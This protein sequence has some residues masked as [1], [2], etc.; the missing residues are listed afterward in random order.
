MDEPLR[1]LSKRDLEILLS[2]IPP[3]PAPKPH[4]EQY[5]T[6]PHLAARMLWV[7]AVTFRD[8]PADLVLDLG[9][10]TGRLGLGAALLGSPFVLLVDVDFE[11]LKRALAAARELGV[12]AAVDA[13]CSDVTRFEISRVASCTVQNPPFG[14]HRRGADVKF[15]SAALR[16]SNVVYSVHKAETASYLLRKCEEVGAEAEAL[17]EEVVRLPPTMPYHFKREHRVRVIVLRAA[18]RGRKPAGSSAIGA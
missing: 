13:V 18:R 6:P 4:L 10:G 2:K 17:F 7:A 8:L 15:L 11:A 5:T 14:V 12:D 3:L 1:S 16:L 9:A